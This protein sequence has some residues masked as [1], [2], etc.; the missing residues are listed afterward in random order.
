[1][2]FSRSSKNSTSPD[3]AVWPTSSGDIAAVWRQIHSYPE[4]EKA[5]K[6][7]Q[8]GFL[9][10]I[11]EIVKQD[12]ALHQAGGFLQ[13]N[14]VADARLF[15]IA[16]P[17]D[18][19]K[20]EMVDF[21]G[22][23]VVARVQEPKKLIRAIQDIQKMGFLKDENNYEGDY[24]PDL[25]LIVIR[26]GIHHSAVDAILNKKQE[27]AKCEVYNIAEA[28]PLMDVSDNFKF[29]MMSDGEKMP[30]IEPR[31]AL[32]YKLARELQVGD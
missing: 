16:Y 15:P 3:M 20:I 29:W 17:C 2:L 8:E 6:E 4:F 10:F 1:M 5:S 19:T 27:Q 26:N 24:Y 7:E 30:V 22:N 32:L 28:Y 21:A 13:H 25:S 12:V 9:Q 31:F 18:P 23:T 11:L 14:V